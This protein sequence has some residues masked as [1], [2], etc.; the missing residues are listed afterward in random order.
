[1][2]FLEAK[3]YYLSFFNPKF[4]VNYSDIDQIVSTTHETVNRLLE[5]RNWPDALALYFRY[6]QQKKMQENVNTL[7]CV[8]CM[9]KAVWW[10]SVRFYNAKKILENLWLVENVYTR[11]EDWKIS[12]HWVKVHFITRLSKS[13]TI[14]PEVDTSVSSLDTLV[15]ENQSLVKP[16]SGDQTRNTLVE[17]INTPEKKWNTLYFPLGEEKS[18]FEIRKQSASKKK[19]LNSYQMEQGQ[20]IWD[21]IQKHSPLVDGTIEDCYFLYL[22][23]KDIGEVPE[24]ALDEIIQEMI[25]SGKSEYYSY[26]N[27]RKLC[28][29]LGTLICKLKTKSFAKIQAS[30]GFLETNDV[31]SYITQLPKWALSEMCKDIYKERKW[32]SLRTNRVEHLLDIVRTRQPQLLPW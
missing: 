15:S 12:S 6:I 13:D 2:L 29:N 11:G 26:A 25:L 14:V 5:F 9:K 24:I 7:S 27:P 19:C 21:V 4:M 31:E 22:K 17:K 3:K 30:N 1:M 28:D 32:R 10:W 18:F 8:R 16:D 20:L 23:I